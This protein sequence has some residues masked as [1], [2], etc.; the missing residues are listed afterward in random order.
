MAAI[1]AVRDGSNW[2]TNGEY[3]NLC[4]FS[5]RMLKIISYKKKKNL[6]ISK[7]TNRDSRLSGNRNKKVSDLA[8]Y[9]WSVL[10]E[11]VKGCDPSIPQKRMAKLYF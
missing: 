1:S 10:E 3:N 11:S 7:Q 5:S 9:Y 6:N 4:F 2:A 8:T